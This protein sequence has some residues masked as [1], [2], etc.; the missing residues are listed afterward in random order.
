[1]YMYIH[2]TKLLSVHPDNSNNL[3]T[4]RQNDTNFEQFCHYMSLSALQTPQTYQTSRP[5]LLK[6]VLTLL[7]RSTQSN[8][9]VQF[10]WI[11]THVGIQSNK[12][13]D[14]IAKQAVSHIN[15]TYSILLGVTEIYSIIHCNIL[16]MYKHQLSTN[17]NFISKIK[18]NPCTKPSNYHAN[19]HNDRIITRLRVGKTNL[20]DDLGIRRTSNN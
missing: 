18:P 4:G 5:D 17:T 15:L 10:Q 6:T 3:K 14:N 9:H 19:I 16:N 12:T 1:M 2:L 11:P 7:H 13:V 8:Q 20:P